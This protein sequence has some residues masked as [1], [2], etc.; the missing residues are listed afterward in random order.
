MS[1]IGERKLATAFNGDR[2]DLPFDRY[3]RNRIV[4]DTLEKL[5]E[6]GRPLRILDA[7]GKGE[8]SDFLP[9]DEVVVS[10][11]TGNG[12][13]AALPFEDAAFDYVVSVDALGCVGA[14]AR[15][16]YLSELRRTARRGVLLAAPFYSEA[17]REAEKVAGEL[18]HSV[19]HSQDPSL[20]QHAKNGLPDLGYARHFFED[21][22]DQVT[23]L[24]NG[25]LPHW[26][27]MTCLSLYG[28]G[29]DGGSSGVLAHANAFYN[30]FVYELDNA[31]PC[32]RHLLVS[33]REPAGDGLEGLASPPRSPER[34]ARSS[35]LFGALSTVLPLVSGMERLED[36]LARYEREL[37]QKDEALAREGER[38][39]AR[40]AEYERRLLEKEGSLA[41]KEAQVNDLSG[42]IAGLIGLHEENAK[43]ER[44]NKVLLG[45]LT[46]IT[47]SRTWALLAGPRAL[48]RWLLQLRGS[49]E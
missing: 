37:A 14:G 27:A 30:E 35:S 1:D 21:H 46:Q 5:R 10:E 32:Y 3:Q 17:V 42:R 18:Y 20:R 26:L 48:R 9:A 47:N 49:S 15:A 40:L 13:A 23:V 24:P 19:Y 28:S 44:Q 6:S 41:R 45:Q 25:Y 33:L 16:E 29:L 12:G 11:R 4:A 43:L 2:L 38:Y 34:T 8:I 31:E 7:A 39:E 36:R 22:G